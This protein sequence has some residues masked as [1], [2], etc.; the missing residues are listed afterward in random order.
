MLFQPPF[1]PFE[2]TEFEA[3][4][5]TNVG[6]M[7]AH[8]LVLLILICLMIY[9]YQKMQVMV[10]VVAVYA[11]SLLIGL[12]SLTHVH[13]PF[14]PTLEIFFLVFQSVMILSIALEVKKK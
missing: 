11:F 13:T 4:A 8:I 9:L 1:D 5:I 14:S 12:E 7:F 6:L 3:V 10:V 2:P